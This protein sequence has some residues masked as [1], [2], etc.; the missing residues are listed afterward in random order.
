[1]ELEI[2]TTEGGAP[3]PEETIPEMPLEPKRKGWKEMT[4]AQKG[5]NIAFRI[6]GMVLTGL[7]L[8]DLKNRPD[9]R[10]KGK[11][12]VWALVSLA[13]PIGPIIYFIFG[14]KKAGSPLAT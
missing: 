9:D 13:Q 3:P 2:N 5:G 6:I 7:A 12:G 10:I 14:R 1:M 4:S 11:K 8:W